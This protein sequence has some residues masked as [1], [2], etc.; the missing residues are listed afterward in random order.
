M[1][2]KKKNML[3]KGVR[4]HIKDTPTTETYNIYFHLWFVDNMIDC[5]DTHS[6]VHRLYE[7]TLTCTTPEEAKYKAWAI[8]EDMREDFRKWA[9]I[10]NIKKKK[11]R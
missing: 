8:L 2:K 6:F 10:K 5:K 9:K 1:D 11:K 7:E 4:D 3:I